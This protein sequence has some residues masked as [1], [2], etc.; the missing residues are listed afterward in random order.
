V[1]GKCLETIE[2]TDEAASIATAMIA[3]G[4]R[5][6]VRR[7][8]TVI[9]DSTT[10]QVIARLPGRLEKYAIHPGGRLWAGSTINFL[11]LEI[12]RLEDPRTAAPA[13]APC[14]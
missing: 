5:A 1:T 3:G 12:L 10:G 11:H 4:L 6:I 8:E 9:E 2:G 13:P 7:A 14:G